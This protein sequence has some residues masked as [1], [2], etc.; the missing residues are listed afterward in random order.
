MLVFTSVL[1]LG[2]FFTVFIITDVR[3]YKQRKVNSMISLAQVIGSNG[4]STLQFQDNEAAKGILSELHN[5]APEIVHAA[6]ID[7]QGKIFASYSKDGYQSFQIPAVLNT[8]TSVFTSQY[9]LVRNDILFDKELLGKVILE[10]ELTELTQIKAD[11]VRIASISL[12][13]AI[14]FTFLIAILIQTYISRRLL[15]VINTM[16]E[17]SS[18][19]NYDKTITDNSKDELSTLIQVFNNLMLHVKESQQRKDEFISI[20]S[21]ELKTPLTTIKGYLELLDVMED[22]QPNKQFVQKGLV[23][24]K[25]LEK[26]ISDL[27]DVS[28][29]QSGQLKLEMNEFSMDDMVN[30][31]IAAFQMVSGNY[32]ITRT[33]HFNGEIILADKHRIEQVLTNLLSNAIKYS[34]GE[35]RVI[36]DSQKKDGELIIRVRD[37]GMGVAKEEQSNIFERFYRSKDMSDTIVGFGLGLYICRDIIVRHDGKIWVERE[38]KGSSFYFSLPLKKISSAINKKTASAKTGD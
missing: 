7:K 33:G 11:K 29:I 28:K 27:L 32:E 30:E 35:K 26:L 13:I 9:L 1:V 16:K 2:I 10:V 6:I 14:A 18:T 20:V 38:E 24:V 21:H 37:Y 15:N 8:R 23:N 19:G 4:I 36:V 31:T 34:P 25:K 22:K 3:S 17:V 12:L 5:V